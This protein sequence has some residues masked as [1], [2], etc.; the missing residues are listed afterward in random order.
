[1]KAITATT[2]TCLVLVFLFILALTLYDCQAATMKRKEDKQRRI[3][4]G[5]KRYS[6]DC[7]DWTFPNCREATRMCAECHRW[8][9]TCDFVETDKASSSYRQLPRLDKV[10]RLLEDVDY[11]IKSGKTQCPP[12]IVPY[13]SES[14]DGEDED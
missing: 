5:G 12:Q 8:S 3:E 7:G 10:Y 11:W 6:Q 13:D 2:S 1:M 14:Y 9:D 4:T